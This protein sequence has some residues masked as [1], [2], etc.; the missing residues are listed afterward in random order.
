MKN[1]LV[2]EGDEHIREIL[3]QVLFDL[4]YQVYDAGNGKEGIALF[5]SARKFD[6]VITGIRMPDMDGNAVA[7]HI[8]GSAESGMTI[9]AITGYAEEADRNFFDFVVVKPFSLEVLV[10]MVKSV[11]Y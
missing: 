7:K 6:L 11:L 5:N 2:I 10:E 9:A 4:G 1:I 3:R 8:R